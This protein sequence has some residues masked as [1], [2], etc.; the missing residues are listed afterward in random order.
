MTGKWHGTALFFKSLSSKS[1]HFVDL[2]PPNI[3][4]NFASHINPVT[5]VNFSA[6]PH[7]HLIRFSLLSTLSFPSSVSITLRGWDLA[8]NIECAQ[9]INT[10]RVGIE[11]A[12]YPK[13]KKLND[14]LFSCLVQGVKLCHY[15]KYRTP[16]CILTVK[17]LSS[18]MT[19]TA[20]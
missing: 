6:S 12:A 11:E 8:C 17:F 18:A 1:Y 20:V 10:D 4:N 15:R 7:I 14:C 2:F 19:D 9:R 16:K 13:Q 5:S 3:S